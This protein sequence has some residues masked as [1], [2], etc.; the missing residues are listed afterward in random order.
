M[1]TD[2]P[3]VLLVEDDPNDIEI[4][5]LAFRNAGFQ[6]PVF[7]VHENQDAIRYLR[8]DGEY[9]DRARFPLPRLVL[10]DHKIP[11]DEW[12]V[13]KWVRARP[14]LSS[15]P[16]VVLTGSENPADQKRAEEMGANAFHIKPHSFNDLVALI[17]RIA[18]FWL[19]GGGIRG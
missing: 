16:I 10:L 13:L 8:G 1:T 2:G 11:G 5:T 3:A 6:N 15:L 19:M 9:A 12:E 18:E 4:T 7:V 17:H 14:N